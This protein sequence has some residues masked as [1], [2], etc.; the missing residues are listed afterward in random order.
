MPR[1]RA[2]TRAVFPDGVNAPVQYGTRIGA[3][4]LYLLHYQLL[5]VWSSCW[6][7]SSG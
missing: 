4:V 1:L 2:K 3:F 7:I 5:P 6:P